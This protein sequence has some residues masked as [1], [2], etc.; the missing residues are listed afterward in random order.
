MSEQQPAIEYPLDFPIKAM[1]VASDGFTALVVDIVRRHAPDLDAEG[2]NQRPSQGGRYVSVTLTVR[3]ESREQLDNIYR[4]LSAC[5]H[6]LMA[7]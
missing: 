6:V 3:A 2:V 7:L 5:E 1:G 4:D